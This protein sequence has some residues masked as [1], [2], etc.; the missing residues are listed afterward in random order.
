[1]RAGAAPRVRV[2]AMGD[3][4]GASEEDRVN[5]PFYFKIGACRNGDRCNRA[6]VKPER[7]TTLLL[8]HMY[9]NLAES[10]SIANDEE[11]DDDMYAKAQDHVEYFY[12]DVFL[13]LATYGEVE[14]IVVL[15]NV[16]DHMIGNVYCK[17]YN[18]EAAE[19]AVKGLQN[20][21]YGARL[22]QAEYTPVTDFREAR[23]RAF[24]ET[25]C[26]RGGLCNFMHIKHI[27]RA[28]KR[29]LVR[30]MYHEYPDYDP[31]NEQRERSPR[32]KE[33]TDEVKRQTSEERR[34]MIAQWNQDLKA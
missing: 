4:R 11:W 8:P 32:R 16:S 30:E 24:H 28:V 9:P 2:R 1:M 25:R 12:E 22:L 31:R 34:S 26:A 27:P 33:K 5:C 14:D 23:C 19:K 3:F 15:D 7:S 29:R 18:E 6:H 13:T 21:F 10:M 20:R 17:Y